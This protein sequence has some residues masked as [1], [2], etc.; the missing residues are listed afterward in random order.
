MTPL[1]AA[2]LPAAIA[3]LV[4]RRA[5]AQRH[6]VPSAARAGVPRRP[7]RV[8]VTAVQQRCITGMCLCALH[9]RMLDGLP[10][11]AQRAGSARTV[12]S[13][14]RVDSHE[15]P[16]AK[17][18]PAGARTKVTRMYIEPTCALKFTLGYSRVLF[19]AS[20]PHLVVYYPSIT[21]AAFT[22]PS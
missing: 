14:L 5:S 12:D 1:A 11:V 13:L 19:A 17:H 20:W 15:F 22:T 3:A 2:A 8:S 18:L 21:A 4:T 6:N 16:L 7:L 10:R 9:A